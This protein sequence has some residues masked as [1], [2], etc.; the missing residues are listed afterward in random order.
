MPIKKRLQTPP[1]YSNYK[2]YNEFLRLEFN[3]SCAY[4]NTCEPEIGGSQSFHIDHYQP[5][6]KFPENCNT[7]SNLFYSCRNCNQ[8]KGPFWPTEE[9]LQNGIFILN[10]CDHDIEEHLVNTVLIWTAKTPTGL[11][12]IEKLRLNSLEM[13][14]RRKTRLT[15]I[16]Q[17]K[18]LH[19]Q[20]VQFEKILEISTEAH[21]LNTQE[22]QNKINQIEDRIKTFNQIINGPLK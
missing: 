18:E 21:V 10:P 22:I 17:I 8:Y 9:Q 3:Y 20:K 6:E 14:R 16:Q 15:I 4:C 7:Y 5:K 1:L 13:Q 2:L 19:A 11:W 12:N